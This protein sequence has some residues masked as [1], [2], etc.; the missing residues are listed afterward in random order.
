[1]DDH[2]ADDASGNGQNGQSD[3]RRQPV[4]AKSK[5]S[6]TPAKR[7]RKQASAEFVIEPLEPRILFSADL[8]PSANILHGLRDLQADLN[9]T[10]VTVPASTT[11]P[12]VNRSITDFAKL[13]D[14][15]GAVITAAKT[16]YENP[17]H[18]TLAGLADALNL[19]PNAGDPSKPIASLVQLPHGGE[20]IALSLTT[21]PPATIADVDLKNETA[22]KL[23]LGTA[24]TATV[25]A[26]ATVNLTFGADADGNFVVQ[27]GGTASE[28]VNAAAALS[29][30]LAFGAADTTLADGSK[31]AATAT[32]SAELTGSDALTDAS[33]QDALNAQS[34]SAIAKAVV[35]GNGEADLQLTSPKL[36]S[37]E[38]VTI[39]AAVPDQ[40]GS[41]TISYNTAGSQ[42]EALAEGQTSAARPVATPHAFTA[43]AA[44]AATASALGA[45]VQ[46]AITDIS[47]ELTAI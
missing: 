44:P 27:P 6:R 22:T 9:L 41:A 46:S 29:G 10:S 5:R 1:M 30:K 36:A 26:K 25:T 12:F 34:P 32:L 45:Q 13:G 38:S 37:P 35:T 33:L 11:I 17:A 39:I 7:A 15:L 47:N 24:Q 8:A 16:Y 28:T 40:P 43:L 42:L 20:G 18:A 14:P 21:A 31:V 2:F 19:L 4:R 3:H 23:E